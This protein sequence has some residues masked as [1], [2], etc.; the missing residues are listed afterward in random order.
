MIRLT[1]AEVTQ[2]G[3]MREQAAAG[4]IGYWHIYESLANHGNYVADC[5][6]P[7]ALDLINGTSEND[8]IHCLDDVDGMD[9]TDRMDGHDV[10]TAALPSAFGPHCHRRGLIAHGCHRRKWHVVGRRQVG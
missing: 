8:D 2:F 6:Q 4:N 1:T 3:Q 9:R 5:S 7:G 10:Q